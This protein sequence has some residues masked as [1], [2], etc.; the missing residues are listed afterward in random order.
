VAEV[1][2]K[3]KWYFMAPFG[4]AYLD[5]LTQLFPPPASWLAEVDLMAV[6]ASTS[7]P[8]PPFPPPLFSFSAM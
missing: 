5:A 2:V 8:P 7:S 6:V 4:E 3:R 1:A